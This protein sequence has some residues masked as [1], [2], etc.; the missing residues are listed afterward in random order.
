MV[1][2]LIYLDMEK[3]YKILFTGGGTG[4]HLFPLIS[5]ISEVKKTFPKNSIEIYYM[6]PR[7]DIAKEYMEKEGVIIKNIFTGKIRRY[8]TPL[9]VLQNIFD[10][11]IKIPIGIIQAI[12]YIFI[13]SPDL[14]FS[15]GGHGSLPPVISGRILQ[16]PIFLHESDIIPGATNKFLQKFAV[17]VFVSFQNTKGVDKNKI[18]TVGNPVREE[19]LLGD[20]GDAVEMFS[21]NGGKPVLLV[22]GGSQGSERI[23]DIILSILNDMLKFFEVIHQ[24][25][26]KNIKRV[27]SE[28]NVA[29]FDEQLKKYYHVYPF[30]DEEQMKNAYAI[31]D[32]VVSRAGAGSIFEIS[33]NKKPSVLLPLPEAAQDHQTKNAYAYAKSGTAVVLEEQNLTPHFFFEKLKQL[34]SPQQQLR[35]MSS[36][37]G[38][39]S[40]PKSGKV[41]ASYIKE[42]LTR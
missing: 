20:R 25:G 34:F 16:V 15:K 9:S 7:E 24:C 8:F 1:F 17:E 38:E 12:F 30:F 36:R 27:S 28:S 10:L 18:I 35:V 29:I 6:G 32:L 41:I 23:N 5:V 31:A 37:A 33:A 19:L 42:Y 14:I 3:R 21:I 26:E 11:L 4:G 13:M 40:N 2:F 22:I 39:F